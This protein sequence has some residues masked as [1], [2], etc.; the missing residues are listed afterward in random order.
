MGDLSDTWGSGLSD[1]ACVALFDALSEALEAHDR[2]T[3]IAAVVEAVDDGRVSVEQL[4]RDVLAAVLASSGERW[5]LGQLHVWQEHFVSA[6]VRTI[7]EL[8][9]DHVRQAYLSWP[10]HGRAV[11]LACP[12]DETHDLGLRML[13]D[14][15]AM[16]G[17]NAYFL[18]SD[19]PVSEII[20]A[21][22]E[23]TVDLVCLSSSTHFHR[24]T[25]REVYDTVRA[26]LPG[27]RVVAGGPAFAAHTE[28]WDPEELVDVEALLE[29]GGDAER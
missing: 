15:F 27:V 19:T 7:V 6:T 23:L 5:R 24:L 10:P 2:E 9:H 8:M 28:G 25:L 11:L 18:G 22:R 14:R 26:Q 16:G 13:A 12:P 21:G 20:A 3:A 29:V 1:D 4:Y 17:W